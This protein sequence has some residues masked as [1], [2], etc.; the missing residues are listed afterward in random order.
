MTGRE[1]YE[2]DVRRRPVYSHDGTPRP[3]WDELDH[4]AQQS[5]VKSP[6]PRDWKPLPK[7]TPN[8]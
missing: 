6:S 8:D 4:I 3:P 2:A 7:E 5:W 1:A